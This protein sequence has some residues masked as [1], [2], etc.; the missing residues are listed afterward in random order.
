MH[1]GEGR[2]RKEEGNSE[3]TII[4]FCEKEKAGLK[5]ASPQRYV[6]EELLGEEAYY[7]PLPEKERQGRHRKGLAGCL[8]LE[9]TWADDE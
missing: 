1:S 8:P 7:L 9:E 2:R 6:S 5:E 4:I 3:G